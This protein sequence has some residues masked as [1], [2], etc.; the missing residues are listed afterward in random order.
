MTLLDVRMPGEVA[1]GRIEGFRSIPLDELRGRLDE[2]PKDKP[3]YVHCH[4]GLRSYLACCILRGNGFDCY[5]L[6]GGWRLYASAV[7][8][9]KARDFP[10]YTRDE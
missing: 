1:T 5:N 7:R 6:A 8:A 2:L 10:C 4:S 3:I 9:Q